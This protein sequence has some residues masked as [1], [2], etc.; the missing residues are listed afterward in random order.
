MHSKIYIKYSGLECPGGFRS[1]TFRKSRSGISI[2]LDQI[3]TWSDRI[4]SE[5]IDNVFKCIYQI[6]LNVLP[7]RIS[8]LDVP[9]LDVQQLKKKRKKIRRKKKKKNKERKKKQRK[10]IKLQFAQIFAISTF[11]VISIGKSGKSIELDRVVT[12][13][14]RNRSEMKERTLK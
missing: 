5:S 2:E 9:K 1:S 8:Q 13:S 6:L 4:R 12:R 3:V 10:Q 14:A 7:G 11:P